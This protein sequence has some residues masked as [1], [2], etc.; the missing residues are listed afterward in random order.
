MNR[1]RF[2]GR[3]SCFVCV[4]IVLFSLTILDTTHA[5][6]AHAA[7]VSGTKKFDAHSALAIKPLWKYA[8]K[9]NVVNGAISKPNASSATIPPCLTSTVAPRC[10][11]PQQIRTAYNIQPLLNAGITGKGQTVVLIDFA[12]S[13][14][15][16]SDVHLYDQLY[17]LKD[18]K[19][20]VISP[21]SPPSVN[22]GLYTE[23]ALDVETVHSIAP[24][25]TIDLVL[26]NVDFVNSPQGF[27][28]GALAVT[29]YAIDHDLGSVISQSFGLGESCVGSAY[30][31]QEQMVFSKARAKGITVLASS[32]D[33]GA[34]VLICSGGFFTEGQ[35]VN[36]PAS[37]PLV[38]SV[39]GTTLDATVGTGKYIAETT[40]N[41]DNA[42]A[43]TT[44]GGVST[45]FP[46]P[47][48]QKGIAGLTGR[49]VPDVAFDADPLTG[50][51][52]VFSLQGVTLIVPVGGTSVGSPAW[53]AVVALANQ[54]A[55]KRL[56]F[57]N[58]AVY[59]L[60]A[61]KSYTNGFHDI[62]TG[63]NTVTIIEFDPITGKLIPVVI[64]GY[65]AGPGW[66]AVTGAGTPKAN[67][68]VSLLG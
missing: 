7:S 6:T 9:L 41:E 17:G 32:G 12:T 35:G 40:W 25:A 68:L 37:D 47:S 29:Q 26:A 55:G 67:A 64:P 38:T 19:I 3:L 50:V 53:A 33:S 1:P 27:L 24:D 18:P 48:Y 21:F 60:L 5:P 31:Q 42:G 30:L 36:L 57:L 14:S 34:A 4:L 63:N 59:S 62:T 66:D 11:D 13:T 23:T 54:H 58:D 52:V 22:P 45:L 10:Y 56:G 15:L 61:S 2:L 51:P 39:G 46:V 28:S 16:A 43:G 20:N 49:G 8:Q 65:N 44:G